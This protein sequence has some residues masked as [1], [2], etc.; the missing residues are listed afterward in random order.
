MLFRGVAGS[1]KT[2][3]FT[4]RAKY[5]AE[6]FPNLRS[7]DLLLQQGSF[8]GACQGSRRVAANVEVKQFTPSRTH[9]AAA[10]G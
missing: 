6:F 9:R 1:G 4:Y 10:E 2:L 5:L 8:N 7:I 3:V